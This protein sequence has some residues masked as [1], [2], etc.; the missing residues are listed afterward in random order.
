M[1]DNDRKTYRVRDWGLTSY[2]KGYER[3]KEIFSR[4]LAGKGKN[5]LVLTRHEPTITLG[6][7]SSEEDILAPEK[8]LEKNGVNVVEIG[9]GGGV[10]YHGP[11]Q[12]VFYPIFDL[13]DY[14]KDLRG[15]I[16]RLGSVVGETAESF[17]LDTEFREGEEIGL[18]LEGERE[19][20]A[21]IGLRVKRWYT[22][23]GVALN[24]NLD[25]QKAGLIRP[26]GIRDTRLASITD[27][28]GVGIDDVKE[29]LLFQFKTEFS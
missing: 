8:I 10:T 12:L 1:S 14:D 13:G 11:G 17:G 5:T 28:A 2:E 9:R 27:F 29:E 25:E 19:K 3:Q 4:R 26:C 6:K 20:L 7:S 24:V 22:M 15:F 18:W 16:L 23:H 21:S